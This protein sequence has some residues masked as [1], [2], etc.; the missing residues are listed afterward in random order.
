MKIELGINTGFALN[1]YTAPEQWVPVVAETLGLDKV[2]FTADLLNPAL[3]PHL[4]EETLKQTRA[5][6]DKYG[7]SVTSTFTS[8]F[9]RVNHFGHP[10]ETYRAYW[11]D[12]FKKFVDI[13][14][15]LDAR[16]MGS[17]FGILTV[18]DL[19]DE[20]LR[21]TRFQQ[22]LACWHQVAEYAAQKGLDFLTWEPMSIAREY[23]ETLE[24]TEYIQ[25]ELNRNTSLPFLL[26]LDVDHGDV[27]SEN[28]DDTDPYV[29]LEK[30][31]PQAPL[32]HIKQSSANKGG[33]W[34][35]TPEHNAQ[36]RIQPEKVIQSLKSSGVQEV[37]LLLEL[38]F[39]E[40]EPA[41]SHMVTSLQQSVEYWKP[42][43]KSL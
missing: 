19:Q 27:A 7:V 38:S 20:C 25:N 35:F 43:C 10:S 18:P 17:H 41:E 21:A 3:P 42:Y 32:I 36:G 6:T 1:R 39:R 16:S 22:N 5:L 29:W 8:A 23:G 34:P 14:C 26:C 37:T 15:A 12:W 2:Q 13:S 11:V 24:A 28:P 30:F 40:R 9:T 33:H 31:G 4:I